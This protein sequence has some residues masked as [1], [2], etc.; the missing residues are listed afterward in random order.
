MPNQPAWQKP[1]QHPALPDQAIHIWRVPLQQPPATLAHFKKQ[2]IETE[3]QRAGRFYFARDQRRYIVA[4]GT[5]RL[6]L[7]RYLAQPTASLPIDYT[8]YNKPY[9]VGSNLNFNVTHSGELALIGFVWHRE[10]GVDIEYTG[11]IIEDAAAIAQRFFSAN[12]NAI[13]QQLPQHQQQTAF[14][15]CW[16]RKEAYIK[17]IGEGLSHPLDTFDV[18]LRPGEPA[19]FLSIDNNPTLTAQWSLT[20]LHPG[21]DYIAALA[22]QSPHTPLHLWDFIPT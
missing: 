20:T 13:F 15:N 16:T 6:L 2:L 19:Q 22:I 21:R 10:I 14:Y 9:L 12:E 1:A 4:R 8:K 5:L 18:T 11:R 3:N 7:S 17:A